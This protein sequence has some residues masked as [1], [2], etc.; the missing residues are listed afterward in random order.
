[1]ACL[2]LGLWMGAGLW[3][4]YVAADNA[5][6]ADSLLL[7]PSAAASAYLKTLGRTPAGPLARY[8][9][10]EQNRSLAETWGMVQIAVAAFFFFFL[11]FGTTQGKVP[12]ALALVMFLI[13]VAERAAFLPEMEAVG[14]ATDFTADP[15]HRVRAARDVLNYGYLMA[16]LAKGLLAAAV[17]GLLIWQRGGRSTHSRHEVDMVDKADHRHI[18]R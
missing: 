3:M 11:L 10:A 1:M 6:A 15:S 17:A 13:A 7:R 4:Q 9:A 18:D 5:A 2:L 14:R 16:E 12:L 8:L